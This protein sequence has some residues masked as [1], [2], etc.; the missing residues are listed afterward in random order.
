[1]SKINNTIVRNKTIFQVECFHN[2]P[3]K[4]KPKITS[5]IDILCYHRHAR[6]RDNIH[7]TFHDIFEVIRTKTTHLLPPRRYCHSAPF[8]RVG[9]PIRYNS[10]PRNQSWSS[11]TLGWVFIHF[12]R[13]PVWTRTFG[14]RFFAD[15]QTFPLKIF[16]RK[17]RFRRHWRTLVCNP[18][19]RIYRYKTLLPQCYEYS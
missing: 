18:M 12:D 17:A 10:A 14:F 13:P 9:T 2:Q 5:A 19:H 1:M 11:K 7:I 6:Q 8:F 15:G 16:I 4:K 3:A